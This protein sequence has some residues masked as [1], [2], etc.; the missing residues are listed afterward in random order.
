MSTNHGEHINATL[1]LIGE[2]VR[3]GEEV[4][5]FFL[6]PYRQRIEATGAV[7]RMIDGK[8]LAFTSADED[9]H[10][11]FGIEVLFNHARDNLYENKKMYQQMLAKVMAEKPDYI[12]H[13]SYT[14]WSKQIAKT[15]NIPAVCTISS[16][17]YCDAM[18]EAAPDLLMKYILRMPESSLP[19]G[20]A[21]GLRLIMD[22]LARNLQR[23]Y[24]LDDFMDVFLA[25]EKL[26][27]VFTS[28]YFQIQAELFDDSFQFVG[29][30]FYRPDTSVDF[31]MEFIT[32]IPL[33]YIYLRSDFLNRWDFYRIC[34]EAFAGSNYRVVLSVGKK[35]TLEQLGPI[36]ANIMV[37]QETPWHELLKKAA[38]VITNEGFDFVYEVLDHGVPLIMLPY[39]ADQSLLAHRV[40]ALEAGVFL[41]KGPAGV[42]ELKEAAANILKDERYRFNSAKIADSFKNA[43]GYTKAADE[44]IRFKQQNH[45][46]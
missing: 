16:F 6:E 9:I 5:Y 34:L 32:D 1:E 11:T 14:L 35:A 41:G 36:P 20:K 12:L 30:S 29:P 22:A 2:L 13:D 27:L 46:V 8:E 33:I 40:E 4:V 45:R 37:M 23:L 21:G 26:N 44:I 10:C 43:G 15:L 18:I 19:K 38:L 31:P 25:R 28:R 3:R 7:F 24:E 17:A 42:L 39:A